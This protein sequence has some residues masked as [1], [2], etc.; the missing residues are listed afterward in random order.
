MA[1]PAAGV[2]MRDARIPD[3]VKGPFSLEADYAN[4]QLYGDAAM[5]VG[6]L[7]LLF[8]GVA[9]VVIGGLS[10]VAFAGIGGFLLV[11]G[12]WMYRRDG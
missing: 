1:D 11:V 10:G 6:V 12:F 5:I 8:A 7:A 2:A 9:A 4:P 3:S